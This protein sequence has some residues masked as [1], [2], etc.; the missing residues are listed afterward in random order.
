MRPR[1]P[2]H[3]RFCLKTTCRSHAFTGEYALNVMAW[4][5]ATEPGTRISCRDG[6]LVATLRGEP[7]GSVPIVDIDMMVLGHGVEPSRGVL[8]RLSAEG[9]SILLLNDRGELVS[10][11]VP[12]S[13]NGGAVRLAQAS[14][15]LTP[16]RRLEIAMMFVRAKVQSEWELL[17]YYARRSPDASI[18]VACVRHQAILDRVTHSQSLNQLRGYE[19]SAA[20]EFFG[21]VASRAPDGW[22]KG[23]RT[24]RPPEDP[25]NVLF[26]LG[27]V[28]LTH[29]MV[30]LTAA[31]GLDPSL[32]FLHESHR[33][34]PALALDLVEEFRA[35]IVRWA[36]GV[37]ARQRVTLAD[38]S[39]VGGV[40]T[41][42]PAAMKRLIVDLEAHLLAGHR[43]AKS[44]EARMAERVR[45]LR[46]SL[47]AVCHMP[48]VVLPFKAGQSPDCNH[49]RMDVRNHIVSDS[50]EKGKPEKPASPHSRSL[51][52][53]SL[54][55][56]S[57]EL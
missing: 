10:R 43:S 37:I 50:N 20:R 11:V 16:A 23:T 9:L 8:D 28:I 19:G 3:E 38:F 25:L 14:A 22:W 12:N 53:V 34:H 46:S 24:R 15:I 17:K 48:T 44:V 5:I 57:R 7:R 33:G 2:P 39:E 52:A 55:S 45:E 21:V 35:E 29:R 51:R 32:G 49:R 40:I 26:S 47:L 30:S 4:V 36:L 27:F 18:R 42:M 13:L 54:R 6:R 41:V 31:A 56:S 1:G